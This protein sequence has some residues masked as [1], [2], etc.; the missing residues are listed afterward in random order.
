MHSVRMRTHNKD[1]WWC[2]RYEMLHVQIASFY[3]GLWC[4]NFISYIRILG[5]PHLSS[6]VPISSFTVG[7]WQ[8]CPAWFRCSLRKS[9]KQTEIDCSNIVNNR[10]L[11]VH[12]LGV[13]PKFDTIRYQ[14]YVFVIWA[15][16]QSPNDNHHMSF[17]S[18]SWL[19]SKIKKLVMALFSWNF[20]KW[21][22]RWLAPSSCRDKSKW[23]LPYIKAK[24][25]FSKVSIASKPIDGPI[26]ELLA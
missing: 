14:N 3:Y 15:L 23:I 18:V 6:L 19:F 11:Y 13:D 26:S 7:V 8:P 5:D 10:K 1:L 22:F 24:F 21:F 2:V 17:F 4:W 16:M 12:D 20:Y 9:R 25:F